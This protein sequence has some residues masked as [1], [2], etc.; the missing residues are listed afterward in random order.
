MNSNRARNETISKNCKQYTKSKLTMSI[1]IIPNQFN[2]NKSRLGLI[3]KIGPRTLDFNLT[4]WRPKSRVN[5]KLIEECLN[6]E[7]ELRFGT[8]HLAGA[9]RNPARRRKLDGR[10]QWLSSEKNGVS[11]GWKARGD[12]FRCSW[13]LRLHFLAGESPETRTEARRAQT[14]AAA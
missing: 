9:H 11:N 3:S 12:V 10:I 4:N 13:S 5:S 7:R 14:D 8:S 6:T 1:S 2:S